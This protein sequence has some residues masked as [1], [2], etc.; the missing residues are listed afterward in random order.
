M[1][2]T[3]EFAE[4]RRRLIESVGTDFLVLFR[5]QSLAYLFGLVHWP[6]ERPLAIV[7]DGDETE[8][9]APRLEQEA[10]AETGYI[11][12]VSVYDDYPGLRHPMELLGERLAARGAGPGRALAADILSFPG[13]TG[14]RGPSI[15]DLLPE[16]NTI[17]CGAAIEALRRVK[18]PAELE[19]LRCSALYSDWAHGYLQDQCV[20]GT[21]ETVACAEATRRAL[22][23][24]L[25]T[26]A[27]YD[28]G[29][30]WLTALITLRSQVGAN[31]ALPHAIN[32]NLVLSPGD[33]IVSAA[34]VYVRGYTVELERTMFV[35][36]PSREQRRFFDHMLA[37]QALAKAALR[38]G[39]SCGDVDAEVRDYYSSH[40][41]A[42][43]WR[44]HT[45]H[46][47][48]LEVHEGPFLDIGDETVIEEGMV[49]SVE[50]GVYVPGLGGFRHSDTAVVTTDGAEFLG[51]YPRDLESLICRSAIGSPVAEVGPH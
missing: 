50:P 18:T 45:G 48:G 9:L 3:T 20:A 2:A 16:S 24:I 22:D 30:P 51:N 14:Y 7:V 34:M 33:V 23:R 28:A 25:R 40:E 39:R 36:E 26:N 10:L 21:N 43:Y 35:G 41:L 49:F 37:I 6:S 11:D 46:G 15:A 19:I 8:A 5:A 27:S 47:L 44:H 32:R 42:P 31:A 1:L 17:A 4:R 38:P 13:T 29:Q 12:R